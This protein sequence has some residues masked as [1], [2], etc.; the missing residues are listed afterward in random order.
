VHIDGTISEGRPVE[1][2]GAHVK[3]HNKDSIGIAYVGGIDKD[4]FQP[5]DTRTEE[6][7]SSLYEIIMNL[8]KD[9]PNATLHG[10]NEFSS[11]ACPSFEVA[12]EYENIICFFG[13]Q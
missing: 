11:K 2:Q 4:N 8:M 10:H 13:R 9:Y 5:L 12:K 3:S 7:I 6:Q 1:R